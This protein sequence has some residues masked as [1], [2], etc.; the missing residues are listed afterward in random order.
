MTC[1]TGHGSYSFILIDRTRHCSCSCCGHQF[2]VHLGSGK[3]HG[4]N[5]TD[6]VSNAMTGAAFEAMRAGIENKVR[7][8]S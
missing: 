5:E 6:S 1:K 4:D 2:E 8:W 3:R 7:T